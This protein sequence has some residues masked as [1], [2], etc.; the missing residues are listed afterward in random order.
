VLAELGFPASIV[1]KAY[2]SEGLTTA[3]LEKRRWFHPVSLNGMGRL[4]TPHRLISSRAYCGET[5]DV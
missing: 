3:I 2:T 1:A 5:S 4:F